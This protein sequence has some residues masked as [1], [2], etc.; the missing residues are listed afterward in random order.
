MIFAGW[1]N[2]RQ[3]IAAQ[4]ERLDA[5]VHL[6]D[7]DTSYG[8]YTVDALRNLLELTPAQ[9]K[10]IVYVGPSIPLWTAIGMLRRYYPEI[11]TRHTHEFTE[12]IE[13]ANR[14]ICRSRQADD[15]KEATC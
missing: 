10:M 9:F 3:E 6:A 8:A 12:T 2:F 11:S 4:N 5:I 14:L 1:Q 7:A 15:P 13:A